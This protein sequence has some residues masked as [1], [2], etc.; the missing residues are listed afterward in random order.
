M[1][2]RE[3]EDKG[4]RRRRWGKWGRRRR[5]EKIQKNKK[6]KKKGNEEQE[7][8]GERKKKRWNL[9]WSRETK[10][11]LCLTL[12][13][14]PEGSFS[15]DSYLRIPSHQFDLLYIFMYGGQCWIRWALI[16]PRLDF[17]VVFVV[18][19]IRLSACPPVHWFVSWLVGSLLLLA[20]RLFICQR[21]TISPFAHLAHDKQLLSKVSR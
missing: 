21:I 20:S 1:K 5:K 8:K 19:V 2:E 12:P 14:D 9:F 17:V 15:Q 3:W 18:V 13:L 11:I 10:Q 7:E 16:F 6:T 4:R